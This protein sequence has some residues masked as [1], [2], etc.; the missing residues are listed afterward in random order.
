[1]PIKD[2]CVRLNRNKGALT[3]DRKHFFSLVAL[4]TN[5]SQFPS[6]SIMPLSTTQQPKY[7]FPAS[8]HHHR[9]MQHSQPYQQQNPPS[10]PPT[11]SRP[12]SSRPASFRAAPPTSTST[13]TVR[14]SSPVEASEAETPWGTSWKDL[15][16]ELRPTY[17]ENNRLSSLVTIITDVLTKAGIPFSEV[18]I[19]DSF[20]HG[21]MLSGELRLFIYVMY[22][23]FR[24]DAYF[25]LHLNPIMAAL[26]QF[27]P[28]Q[29]GLSAKF[30]HENVDIRVF[31]AGTLQMGQQSFCFHKPR[32]SQTGKMCLPCKLKPPVP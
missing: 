27:S 30:L 5:R 31:A 21:T 1:M 9:Q 16:T 6:P 18:V 17:E 13:M 14:M 2:A 26:K 10:N 19:G 25:E 11:P 32:Q 15:L 28:T 29:L 7:D 8:T 22:D 4:Q 3:L 24:P 23:Q 12:T 20:G